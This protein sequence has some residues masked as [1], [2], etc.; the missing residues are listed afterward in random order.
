MGSE[1]A[2]AFA[3][4]ETSEIE[5]LNQELRDVSGSDCEEQGLSRLSLVIDEVRKSL[6]YLIKARYNLRLNN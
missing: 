1:T 3:G 4:R 5:E 2:T 6:F